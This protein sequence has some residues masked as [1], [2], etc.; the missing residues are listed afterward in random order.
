MTEQALVSRFDGATLAAV[1]LVTLGTVFGEPALVL[2]AAVPLGYLVI[3]WI[4]SPPPTDVEVERVVEPS[5]AAP[6]ERVAVTLTVRNTGETTLTD[7]RLVDGVPTELPV[8]DGSPRACLSLRPGEAASVEYA[9]VPS[10]GT[11]EF[12]SPVTRCRSFSAAAM[13]T[14]QPVVTGATTL[15]C[16]RDAGN[17]PQMSGSLRR[18]GTR[19]SDRGGEGLEFH[20]TREYRLGDGVSRVDWR[21]FAKN[22]SLATIRFTETSATETVVIVYGS[23]D[24]RVARESGYP[25]ANELAVYAADRVV[26]RLFADGNDVGLWTPGIT[27]GDVAVPTPSDQ[28]GEPWVAPG[29][30]DS[31]RMRIDAVFDTL[32]A[33]GG[34]ES[35]D[36]GGRATDLRKRLPSTADVVVVTPA[37]NGSTIDLVE[38]IRAADHQ[39][40][41]VSPDITDRRS[42]GRAVSH[43][44]RSLR[45]TRLR[46]AGAVVCDWDTRLPLSNAV[47]GIQ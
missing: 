11:Y 25:T 28:R 21:R 45:L 44:E 4:A 20:S 30:D 24:G 26:A 9:V 14:D 15:I 27:T 10:Q 18:V 6:G 37:L 23:A 7:I 31:T 42:A 35:G 17:V 1:L 16:R 36:L 33:A 8:A 41:V 40:I 34:T 3:D 46:K 38:E 22:G 43:V 32:V 39:V 29:S 19:P 2:A 12:E 13:S 5:P 47:D